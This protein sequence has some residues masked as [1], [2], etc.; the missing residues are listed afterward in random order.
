LLWDTCDAKA[1]EFFTE[2]QVDTSVLNID[3]EVEK[4]EFPSDEAISTGA[5]EG[6]GASFTTG[7]QSDQDD[8]ISNGGP[9]FE[10]FWIHEDE[11]PNTMSCAKA[12]EFDATWN[13]SSRSCRSVNSCLFCAAA[14]RLIEDHGNGYIENEA[15]A[16]LM[17]Y[18][19]DKGGTDMPSNNIVDAILTL[20]RALGKNKFQ[21]YLS[22]FGGLRVRKERVIL[23]GTQE[24]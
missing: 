17:L 23:M 24:P 14:A 8:T 3:R 16:A 13:R 5:E 6:A 18:A 21:K 4:E 11:L 2:T 10:L 7:D 1:R 20:H 9:P 22:N 19:K 15:V 12:R